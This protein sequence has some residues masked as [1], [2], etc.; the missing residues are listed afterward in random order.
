MRNRHETYANIFNTVYVGLMTNLLVI[1]G[2]AP[3]LAVLLLT[4]TGQ[5]WPLLAVLAPLCAPA[6]VGVFAVLRAF[7][8]EGATAVFTTFG[9]TWRAAWR[10]ATA[11]GGLAAAALVVLG[12][13]LAWTRRVNGGALAVPVLVVLAVLVVAT[14]VLALV[15]LAER[16]AV[17]LRDALK[18]CGFLAIRRWYLTVATLAVLVV[19]QLLLAV[20]PL[21]ALGIASAP[22][23]YLVWANSRF[24][25]RPALGDEANDAQPTD[26]R[27]PTRSATPVT[28][29]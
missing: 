11:L 12:V 25:L 27:R 1:L 28:H 9:R 14:T 17:R 10:R 7:S 2:C 21:A 26:V 24:T 13:D 5:T 20:S 3:A 16:P 8:Q 4:D 22:V 18:V 23:L 6:L 29:A 19:A 15:A